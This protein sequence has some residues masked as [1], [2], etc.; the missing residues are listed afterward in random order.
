MITKEHINELVEK[1]IEGTAMF[2]TSVQV[3]PGNK[4]LVFLD[5]DH[6]VSIEDCVS[7][8]RFIETSLNRDKD[9]F[10]LNVSSHGLTSPFVLPRQYRNYTGKPVTVLFNNGIKN[11]GVIISASD[12]HFTFLPEKKGKKDRNHEEEQA[13]VVSYQEVKEVKPIISFK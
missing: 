3:K 2:V 7:V 4:I 5:G 13:V 1:A 8:S 9:D 11:K 12:T 10:E 6:G